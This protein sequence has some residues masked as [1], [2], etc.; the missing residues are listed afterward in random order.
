MLP[1]TTIDGI[2]ILDKP[3]GLTSNRCLQ[4][5]KRL[6]GSDKAGHTGA[7]DPLASGVLPLCFGEATKVSQFLLD[8]DKGY[9]AVIELGI[10]T[11]SGDKDGEVMRREAVPDLAVPELAAVLA[12]FVGAQ[13]QEAPVY[14]ALK[15]GG[16]PLYKLARAGQP[17]IPKIREIHIHALDLLRWEKPFLELRVSCS[18]GTYIRKLGEDIGI[19]LGTV[20]CLAALRREKAGPFTLAQALTLERVEELVS[21]DPRHLTEGLL[22]MD[23]ALSHLPALQ[24]SAEQTLHLRQGKR[25]TVGTGPIADANLLRIYC[26]GVF[27]GLAENEAGTLQ[28]KRLLSY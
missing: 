25:V 3:L 8:A 21:I 18:K 26:E 16:V 6:L 19:A 7:L 10:A 20:G 24:V 5:V 22:P 13:V 23:Q 9:R 14:S 4:I 11:A 15:Q 1:N 12:G 27:I 2:L 17:V 28:P